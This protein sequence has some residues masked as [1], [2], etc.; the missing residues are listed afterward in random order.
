[1]YKK[2]SGYNPDQLRYAIEFAK[3][4]LNANDY[5]KLRKKSDWK[6]YEMAELVKQPIIFQMFLNRLPFNYRLKALKEVH[7]LKNHEIREMRKKEGFSGQVDNYL[8]GNFQI[9]YEV[10]QY[11]YE[12]AIILD[13]PI[14]V[15][16]YENPLDQSVNPNSFTEYKK[17]NQK[18]SLQDIKKLILQKP[19][20]RNING[21]CVKEGNSFFD[22]EYYVRVDQRIEFF[23]FEIFVPSK[24]AITSSFIDKYDQLLEGKAKYIFYSSALL[25]DEFKVYYFGCYDDNQND[26]FYMQ[27]LIPE[28]KERYNAKEIYPI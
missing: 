12:L 9:Q 21:F 10:S 1:M 18:K 13:I 27:S 28:I 6:W 4:K 2:P 25:R 3:G 15:L 24:V 19:L 11:L 14:E 26:H 7:D 8:S 23:S 22:M 17:S 20:K 16:I 5:L